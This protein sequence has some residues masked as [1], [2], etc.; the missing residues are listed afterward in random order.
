[1]ASVSTSFSAAARSTFCPCSES[2]REALGTGSESPASTVAPGF[3]AASVESPS[4]SSFT[5]KKNNQNVHGQNILLVFSH[6]GSF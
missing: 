6:K 4:V 5:Y 1:M 2:L 3:E